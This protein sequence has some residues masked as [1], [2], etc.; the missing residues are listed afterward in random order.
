MDEPSSLSGAIA[1]AVAES[2]PELSRRLGEGEDVYA[3]I[4]AV[5][6][7]A[8]EETRAILQASVDSA[9]RAGYSW[10]DVGRVLGVSKQAAQQ[11]FGRPPRDVP[12]EQAREVKILYPV[13]AFNEMTALGEIGRFGWRSVG[14]GVRFHRIELTS[15]KWEHARIIAT[16]GSSQELESQG[17]VRVGVPSFPWAYFRRSLGVPCDSGPPPSDVLRLIVDRVPPR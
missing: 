11:R 16:A 14:F 9:R 4:L 15:E 7:E 1:R 8:H 3:G 13:N 17:W 5:A 2:S 10:G 6:A 12:P